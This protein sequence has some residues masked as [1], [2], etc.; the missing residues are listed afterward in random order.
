MSASTHPHI[1]ASTQL[2]P[3]LFLDRDG[4]INVE[5]NYLHKVEDFEFIDGIF[6]LCRHFQEQG[7][8]IVVVTNQSGIARGYYN[9]EEFAVLTA[10]M[11][12]AFAKRGITVAQVYHCPHH[13]DITG[14]CDCRKPEAGMLMQA[15]EELGIDLENSVLIGDKERDIDA[16]VN[17][18][19][20]RHYLFD[21]EHHAKGSRATAVIGTLKE[22]L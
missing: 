9:E 8:L 14:V 4:V 22:L 12:E 6:E 3:A 1:H 13:P 2:K 16:A 10:W 19:L 17:A 20:R 18:G 5:K 11:V 7:Y 15:K 21:P